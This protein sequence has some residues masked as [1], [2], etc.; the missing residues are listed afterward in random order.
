MLRKLLLFSAVAIML[1]ALTAVTYADGNSAFNASSSDQVDSSG[2]NDSADGDTG[3]NHPP[4]NTTPPP[5]LNPPPPPGGGSFM[6]GG[7]SDNRD[8]SGDGDSGNGFDNGGSSDAKD[9]SGDGGS[10]K[11][12]NDTG[13]DSSGKF[14]SSNDGDSAGDDN[15]K[16]HTPK[17]DGNAPVPEPATL[18]LLGS[19]IAGVAAKLRN[20]RKAS[21]DSQ[22]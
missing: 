8:S 3:T 9:S 14:D 2:D 4:L 21:E 11:E 19:G 7:S 16:G 18:I 20:R 6:G 22:E 15:G 5:P 10:D 1:T 13:E 17:H 12:D